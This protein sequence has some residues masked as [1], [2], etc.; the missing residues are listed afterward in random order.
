M[1]TRPCP[2][3]RRPA[4]PRAENPAFPFCCARCRTIDLGAWLSEDYRVPVPPEETER[5]GVAE[6][7]LAGKD[8]KSHDE[9]P[10]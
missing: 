7:Q 8:P 6:V 9:L 10:N 2:H 3:C 4:A 1:T 5:D